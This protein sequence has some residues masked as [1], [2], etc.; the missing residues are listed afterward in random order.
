MLEAGWRPKPPT[1]RAYSARA[2][3]EIVEIAG[4]HKVCI[5]VRGGGSNVV[6]SSYPIDC[7][8]ILDV[9][10]LDRILEFR[11][12][13]R[14]VYVEAGIRI[15]RLE[16]WLNKKGY[17]L[18][19]EPQSIKLA[20]V[21]GSIS[22]L[23]TGAYSPGRGNIEDIVAWVDVV[24]PNAKLVRLGVSSPRRQLGPGVLALILG[25]EGS[26]GIIVSAGLRIRELP[27]IVRGLAY[28]VPSFEKAVEAAKRLVLWCQPPVL[29]VI[30]SSE[31]RL[32]YGI[33]SS[34]LIMRIEGDDERYVDSIEKYIDRIVG[35][36]GGKKL[37]GVYE[38]WWEHRYKYDEY[39]GMLWEAGLWMDT[40][41]TS[42]YWSRLARL[43]KRL[44]EELSRVKG[45]SMVFSHAGH[46]Y[47][48]G[49][50]LYHT[51][52]MER[53]MGVY[54]RVWRRTM[55]VVVEE[56]ATITHQHGFGLLRSHWVLEAL[57]DNYKIY[58]AIKS[59]L[60]PNN[61]LNPYGLS[62]ACRRLK[63]N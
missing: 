62:S 56:G 21:G 63:G 54:W 38:K 29:R 6:G 3:Q 52:V 32:F 60:D 34:I 18:S 61:L 7:C 37:E 15:D 45:V 26:L 5:V 17:T 20:T 1:V 19:Y 35:G 41:D 59:L 50:S 48:N 49:G 2:I 16:E 11:P 51:V 8:L 9:R 42:S 10:G 23:G 14:L 44:L 12:E 4:K 30:D 24:L 31:A 43:N 33:D 25:A 22:M 58:C 53:D 39:L 57:G 28:S 13:D 46:F 36:L 27:E 40:I 47:L 55:S